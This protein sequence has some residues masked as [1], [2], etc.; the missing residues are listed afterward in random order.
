[1]ALLTIDEISEE[2][3][4]PE[5]KEENISKASILWNQLD[6]VDQLRIW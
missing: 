5:E 6:E 4:D 3:E 2:F 1:M